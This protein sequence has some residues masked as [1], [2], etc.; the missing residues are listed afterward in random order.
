MYVEGFLSLFFLVVSFLESKVFFFLHR[1]IEIFPS[2]LQEAY[3]N[4]GPPRQRNMGFMGSNR[5][6]PYDRNDRFS[7]GMNA[8]GGGFAGGGYG[9]GRGGRNVKGLCFF[10]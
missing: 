6:G 5:P 3:A 4:V 10:Y 1:Y 9:R 8:M 7:G 2:T